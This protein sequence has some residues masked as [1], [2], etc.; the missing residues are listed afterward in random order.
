MFVVS[1]SLAIRRVAEGK[2]T[3]AGHKRRFP[4]KSDTRITPDFCVRKRV[5]FRN[6]HDDFSETLE[7]SGPG[8]GAGRGFFFA[9]LG[10]TSNGNLKK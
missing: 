3:L 2:G 9:R 4:A 8:N 1:D 6:R 10:I 7:K 5:R